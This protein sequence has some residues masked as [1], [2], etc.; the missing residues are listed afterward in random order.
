QGSK[1]TYTRHD[2][3]LFLNSKEAL[4][5]FFRTD[6]K[7]YH[8]T[9][10]YIEERKKRAILIDKNE[11]PVGGKWT[12]DAENRKKYPVKKVAPAV[13]YP[14]MDTHYEE[15]KMYVNTYFGHHLGEVSDQPLYP[16]GFENTNAWFQQFLEQR[17]MEF[18]TYED[19]IVAENSILHHSVLTPMMNIGLITPDS[20]IGNALEYAR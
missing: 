8:Q 12:F 15:A 19:A 2:S 17:F 5:S 6:K 18:G 20:V 1:I 11:K 9:S 16:I 10:F 7:K 14:D 4:S 13:Q 3:P